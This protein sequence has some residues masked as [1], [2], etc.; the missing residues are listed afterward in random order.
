MAIATVPKEITWSPSRLNL[1]Q[2]CPQRWFHK[3]VL[4][5]TDITTPP[6]AFGLAV[7]EA[8]ERI[9]PVAATLQFGPVRRLTADQWQPEFLGLVNRVLSNQLSE[10]APLT[11]P[12][13]DM[14]E[15]MRAVEQTIKGKL[16]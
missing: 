11:D 3:Y 10:H 15:A 16:S 1:W 8:L 14:Q 9:I 12:I 4:K 6:A 7:H 13:K 2:Q 5:D